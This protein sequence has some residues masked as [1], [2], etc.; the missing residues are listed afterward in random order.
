M[1]DHDLQH[2]DVASLREALDAIDADFAVL[3]AKRLAIAREMGRRKAGAK[4]PIFDR[5]GEEDLRRAKRAA[6]LSAR[7]DPDVIEHVFR[8]IIIESHRQQ[9][10]VMREAQPVDSK[11]IA[12]VGGKGQMGGFFARLL[13]SMGH[14]ILVADIDTELTPEAAAARAQVTIISVPIA[15]TE[16]VIARVGPYVPSDSLFMDITSEKQRPVEAMLTH[17]RA[18]V[19]GVHPMFGPGTDSL[20][21]QVVALC[22]ARGEHWARWLRQTLEGRGAKV[23]VTTP[24]THDRMMSI[25]QVLR[26]FGTIALGAT[27]AELDVDVRE[28]LRFSSPI[29]RLELM[30]IGRIF[31][32]DPALYADIETRN[33]HRSE[34]LD[35]LERCTGKLA[36]IVREGD[37]DAFIREFSRI[38]AWFA[39]FKDQA[40]EES[41]YLISRM[42]DR[43]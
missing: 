2:S 39:D 16:A 1:A 26:H 11:V 24:E 27:L 43:M 21:R 31:S 29:Y 23:L 6:A 38:S 41:A 3:L 37:R 15:L 20:A 18:E 22:P 4:A 14:E 30:M 35:M 8:Q 9:V 7:A 32:Q 10:A 42:V 19:V 40:M 12:I 13:S 17:S 36:A 25:I 34:T 5:P 28:T 33:A